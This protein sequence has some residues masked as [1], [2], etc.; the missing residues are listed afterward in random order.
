MISDVCLMIDA[1]G[2]EELIEIVMRELER[3]GHGVVSNCKRADV[4]IVSDFAKAQELVET[5]RKKTVVVL[6]LPPWVKDDA[7]IWKFASL[8]PTRFVIC[9]KIAASG[10]SAEKALIPFIRNL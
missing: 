8:N 5:C 2:N 7:R 6:Y 9:N 4:V 10:N 1:E 3:V